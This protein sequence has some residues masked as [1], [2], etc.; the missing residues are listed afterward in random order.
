VNTV[1][2]LLPRLDSV[3]RTEWLIYAPPAGAAYAT[4][5]AGLGLYA[6]LLVAAGLFDF[7]RKSL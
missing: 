4:A 3:T 7:Q 5:L 6:L 1:A 2:L